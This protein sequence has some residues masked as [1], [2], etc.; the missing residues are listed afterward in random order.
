MENHHLTQ[1]ICNKLSLLIINVGFLNTEHIPTLSK[2]MSSLTGG[3][4][5]DILIPQDDVS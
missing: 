1:N 3:F 5:R 4:T 2:A